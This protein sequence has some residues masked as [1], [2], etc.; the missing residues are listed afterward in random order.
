[1]LA[2]DRAIERL[3][4]QEERVAQVVKLRFYAGLSVEEVAEVL[5]TSRRTI[6]RDWAFARAWLYREL[7]RG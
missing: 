1:V 2:L 6:L 3:G 4:E 5:E 7:S